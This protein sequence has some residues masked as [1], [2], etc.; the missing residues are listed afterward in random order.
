[1]IYGIGIDLV[2]VKRIEDALQRWGERFQSKVF[3]A[4]E[5]DYC[6]QKKNP[7]PN[8]AAR[9]AAKEGFVKALGLGIRRGVHWKDVEVQH[10]SLGKPILRVSGRALEICRQEKIE[11][12]FL[13][14]T[15]DHEYSS[16]MVVL[17]KKIEE[18]KNRVRP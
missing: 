5:I 14:L 8:F 13:S 4:G 17:Q 15:H 18:R 12:L 16:A 3:T 10:D 2:K 1:M 7:F 9:F 11:G 6:L